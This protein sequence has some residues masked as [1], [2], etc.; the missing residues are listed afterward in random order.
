VLS[1]LAAS[2]PLGAVLP[3]QV[4]GSAAQVGV[5]VV[6]FGASGVGPGG[7]GLSVPG[8][9]ELLLA[10][11]PPPALVASALLAGGTSSFAPFIPDQPGLAGLTVYLQGAAV[12]ASLVHPIE[13]TNALSVKLGP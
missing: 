6:Y 5:S 2:A 11:A 4:T 3:L 12:D 10:L 13:V 8:I 1:A 9:G 7:C